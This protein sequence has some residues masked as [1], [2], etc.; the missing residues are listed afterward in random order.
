MS[1]G[2][3]KFSYTRGLHALG[4][5]AYAWLQPDGSWGE[6]SID[7]LQ[8]EAFGFSNA[9]VLG[10]YTAFVAARAMSGN[11]VPTYP[12]SARKKG[13]EAVIRLK[14]RI[15]ATGEVT[16]VKVVESAEP[17][18]ILVVGG[19]G[20]MLHAIRQHWRR[21]LP[22]LGVN[23]GH[24][25]FLLN[26]SSE[27]RE[28][29]WPSG[30]LLVRRCPLLYVECDGE[31]S[32]LGFNDAWVERAGPQTAWI[33]IRVN[34][35]TKLSRLVSDGAL[36]STAAGSTAYARAMGAT[37]LL[38]ETPAMILVGSNVME[39]PAWRSVLLALDTVLELRTLAPVFLVFNS[40]MR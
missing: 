18:V 10:H 2:S 35:R 3:G 12:E 25:G 13:A 28:G 29:R 17:N 38:V 11:T 6:G 8:M 16:E 15:S 19:D 34:G 30:G 39:P 9:R 1:L 14:V 33:E 36:V 23:A 20:T 27:L 7:S 4:N 24:R 26:A 22:F 32:A 31:R 21:R 37:P 5:G 40:A